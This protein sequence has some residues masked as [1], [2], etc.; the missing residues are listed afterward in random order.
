MF[1]ELLGAGLSFLGGERA[2]EA[3]AREAARN[4]AF[5]E[6]MSSTAHQRQI[7]DLKKAG[8]NPILSA[9]YGGSAT[10]AGSTAQQRDT[11]SPAVNTA[12]AARRQRQELK[13]MKAQDY[14]LNAQGMLTDFQSA[15]AAADA[16]IAANAASVDQIRA[17]LDREIYSGAFGKYLRAMQLG[18]AAGGGLAVGSAVGASRI[19]RN[20]I[21]KFKNQP[22][23]PNPPPY[24]RE[25]Y[26]G[27]RRR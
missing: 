10:P 1:G 23:T 14:V 2:N 17:K 22:R 21:Q 19:Y 4:R 24:R 9:R 8:I 16:R 11:I 26:I 13:N 27:T 3:S 18:G 20:V 25:P 12:L 7:K 6:R 5:Q 15:K